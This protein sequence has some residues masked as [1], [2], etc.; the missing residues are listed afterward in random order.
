MWRREWVSTGR[1]RSGDGRGVREWILRALGA[2]WENWRIFSSCGR[3]CYYSRGYYSAAT[4][5]TARVHER[6]CSAAAAAAAAASFGNVADVLRVESDG[7]AVAEPGDDWRHDVATGG[8]A[9]G[10][11]FYEQCCGYE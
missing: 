1:D 2:G 10:G 5:E 7:G 9:S 4:T 11:K 6:K 8:G 3:E